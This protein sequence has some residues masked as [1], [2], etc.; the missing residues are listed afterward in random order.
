MFYF[1]VMDLVYNS[2]YLSSIFYLLDT[3]Q[4]AYLKPSKRIFRNI[5]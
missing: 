1:V 3:I 4:E 5:C 2:L